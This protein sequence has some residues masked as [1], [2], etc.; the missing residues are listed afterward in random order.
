VIERY[1]ITTPT[2]LSAKRSMKKMAYMI[3]NGLYNISYIGVQNFDIYFYDI[4]LVPITFFS[5]FLQ[6]ICA[7]Q[8]ELS[9]MHT[10]LSIVAQFLKTDLLVI[11]AKLP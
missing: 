10:M 2:P 7:P 6:V 8:R 3:E 11:Y 1:Q 5:Y 4:Y 9:Y